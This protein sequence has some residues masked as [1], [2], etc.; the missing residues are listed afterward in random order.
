MLGVAGTDVLLDNGD[1]L[2]WNIGS[3]MAYDGRCIKDHLSYDKHRQYMKGRGARR[4]AD[5]YTV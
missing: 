3:I 5:C 2:K 1:F 4:N